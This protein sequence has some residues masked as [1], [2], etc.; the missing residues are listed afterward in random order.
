[1]K[2]KLARNQGG[3]TFSVDADVSAAG[4]EEIL[5]SVLDRADKIQPF[6]L[7]LESDPEEED[8]DPAELLESIVEDA[9]Q[10][11]GLVSEIYEDDDPALELSTRIF[12]AAVEL[13]GLLESEE[14]E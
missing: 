2:L 6:L 5:D 3:T 12:E 1:M 4:L 11:V 7:P 8:E 13:S 9:Q 10:L 14:G